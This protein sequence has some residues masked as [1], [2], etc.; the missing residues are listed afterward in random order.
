MST[1][2]ET[3]IELS[4]TAPK[5]DRELQSRRALAGRAKA[6]RTDLGLSRTYVAT[7]AGLI[8]ATLNVWE[9][10]LPLKR[11]PEE[12][13]WE[14]ALDVPSGW[15][16]DESLQALVPVV[17]TNTSVDGFK[18]GAEA[19][20]KKKLTA[21]DRQGLGLRAKL[22]R[23][24]LSM[25]RT[26]V[27]TAVGSHFS[28]LVVWERLFPAIRRP[29]E[30]KW[31]A[32]LQVPMGW[33]RDIS[34]EI[35]APVA[36]HG[37]LSFGA[38]T[39]AA[40]IRIIATWLV[41]SKSFR[42]TF[43]F[44]ALTPEE[45]R[46]VDIFSCRYGVRGED[47]SILNIIG[48]RYNLTRERIRQI[49]SVMIERV[50]GTSFA[51]PKID[52]LTTEVKAV[53]PCRVDQLDTK[54]RPL[55]GETLSIIGAD[56]FARDVLGK[57]IAV[58][59]D[60]PADMALAWDKIVVAPDEH[61][62]EA[63]RAVRDAARAMIRSVGAAQVYFVAGAAGQ[64]LGR[65][66][67]PEKLMQCCRV[68]SGFEWLSELDGWFWFGPEGEN[69]LL[70]IAQKV[71]TIANRSVDG[72]EIHAALVRSRRDR[73]DPTQSRPYLI[74]PTIDIVIEILR[75]LPGVRNLQSNNFKLETALP[76]K[77]ILS[78]TELEIYDCLTT[79]GGVAATA[80]L[81]QELIE[82]GRVK[83]MALHVSLNSTPIVLPIDFGLYALRGYSL[84]PESLFDEA[85]AI[86]GRR[87]SA[88]RVLDCGGGQYSVEFELTQYML[89][90][91]FFSVPVAMAKILRE[92]EYRVEG[93]EGNA[94]YVILGSG[95]RRLRLF[96]NKI[97]EAGFVE[98]DIVRIA[99][100]PKE[101]IFKFERPKNDS[102]DREC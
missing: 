46:L 29:V 30:S 54:L 61:D 91:R 57:A 24:E 22:R 26:Y 8:P 81:R 66:I 68:I 83:H 96:I 69:R 43:D 92:G 94:N 50:A 85:A 67:P 42:R 15:L 73:Y 64:I 5:N 88:Q 79:H 36:Q 70:R 9:Q 58:V 2:I 80:T 31:E 99:I 41:R 65:G 28:N 95:A 60:R 63:L 34:M 4:Q 90:T 16:R 75:R 87:A 82:T 100:D 47:E 10:T 78:E 17:G 20:R 53:V 62:A 6:R 56:R 49:T 72:E 52:Q 44:D 102:A 27:A 77:D 38:D 1:E 14:T 51:T 84:S 98:G 59:T 71:L 101:H 25:S 11:R 37:V 13:A 86:G 93:A 21:V 40:E 89:Q 48:G 55:L 97:V 74:E 18:E 39:V 76:L 7:Q 45:K 32:V 19:L 12:L 33:L 35:P 23:N 3:G